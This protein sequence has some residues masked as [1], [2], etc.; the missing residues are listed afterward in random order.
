ME[1]AGIVIGGDPFVDLLSQ[2]IDRLATVAPSLRQ[3]RADARSGKLT[4]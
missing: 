1:M 3:P 2:R 4:G